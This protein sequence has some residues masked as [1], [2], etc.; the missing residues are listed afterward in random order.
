MMII[1]AVCRKVRGASDLKHYIGLHTIP[2]YMYSHTIYSHNYIFYY[3]KKYWMVQY[4]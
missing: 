4:G 2:Y 3:L 1:L